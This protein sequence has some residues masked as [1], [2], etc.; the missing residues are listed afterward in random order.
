MQGQGQGTEGVG[1]GH[2]MTS[3]S[4]ADAAEALVGAG[5]GGLV[6]HRDNQLV[7]G[8]LE[9]AQ[10]RDEQQPQHA[11]RLVQLRVCRQATRTSATTTCT[12]TH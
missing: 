9:L 2:S 6:L 3:T 10:V 11:R 7:D 8:A 5:I 1:H 4:L 12:Y